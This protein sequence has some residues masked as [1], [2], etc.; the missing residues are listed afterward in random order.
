MVMSL[1]VHV[2]NRHLSGSRVQPF[3]TYDCAFKQQ[4]YS[5]WPRP[6]HP[7]S[8]ALHRTLFS[9]G[10]S[11]HLHSETGGDKLETDRKETCVYCLD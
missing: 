11:A 5:I 3:D 2:K 9:E 6:V 4:T 1:T 10:C 7:S 8:L